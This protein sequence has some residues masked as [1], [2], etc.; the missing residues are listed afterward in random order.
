MD[1]EDPRGEEMNR[2]CVRCSMTT[3]HTFKRSPNT[4]EERC[5]CETCNTPKIVVT[6]EM[7]SERELQRWK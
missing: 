2:Y 5:Y 1:R 7:A 4:G 6:R 3:R